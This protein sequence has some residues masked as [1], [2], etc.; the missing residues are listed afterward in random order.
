MTTPRPQADNRPKE[1]DTSFWLWIT[2]FAL[3]A[4][5]I[6][7]SY[8]QFQKI[9]DE[10]VRQALAE[11]PTLDRS[12]LEDATTAAFGLGLGFVLLFFAVQVVFVFLMRGGRNW[13]RIVLAV[14]GG[15]GL[16]F[17]LVGLLIGLPN[18]SGVGSVIGL[19]Q[20][21]LLAGAIVTMF[22]PAANAWFRP[23]QPGF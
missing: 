18:D 1:V 3:G 13:A 17:G 21:L 4:L 19:L 15:I 16:F 20:L 2:T 10:A 7:F 22:R 6:L 5:G 14:F 9:Q 11:N 8:P 12:T 23:R